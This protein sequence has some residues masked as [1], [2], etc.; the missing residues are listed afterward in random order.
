[1]KYE[2]HINGELFAIGGKF[3]C[4]DAVHELGSRVTNEAYT[5]SYNA[6]ANATELLMEHSEIVASC[7]VYMGVPI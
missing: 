3:A 5:V 4:F 2:L 7:V 1:M 6:L